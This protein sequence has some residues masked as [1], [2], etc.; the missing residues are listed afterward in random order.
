[1]RFFLSRILPNGNQLLCDCHSQSW[2]NQN[3]RNSIR[4]RSAG[5]LVPNRTHQ[6]D[7]GVVAHGVAKREKKWAQSPNRWEAA[8]RYGI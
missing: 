7:D 5:V 6:V 3:V 1:M 2:G 4:G 8:I